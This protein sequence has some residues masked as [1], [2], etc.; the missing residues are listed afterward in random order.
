[1]GGRHPKFWAE[2]DLPRDGAREV[3]NVA[4]QHGLVVLTGPSRIGLTSQ[5]QVEAVKNAFPKLAFAPSHEGMESA[6]KGKPG[7]H[8][9]PSSK[10]HNPGFEKLCE[11]TRTK[12]REITATEALRRVKAGGVRF[13]DV[14]EDNEWADARATGSEHLG[15][16]VL[17]RDIES[18]V[19]DKNQEI[20]LYCGGGFR[21]ALAAESLQRMGYHNVLSMAGGF[22]GWRESGLPEER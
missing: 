14:R 7:H 9:A 8:S 21:S 5:V 4:R 3:E 17:E 1:M 15:R 19:P 16:G 20:I 2:L 18:V 10:K 11:Q 12:I 22:R 6:P 13:L